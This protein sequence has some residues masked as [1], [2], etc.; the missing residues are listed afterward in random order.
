MATEP[1]KELHPLD[2]SPPSYEWAGTTIGAEMV[3]A[4]GQCGAL[5]R[6]NAMP[7]HT[8]FHQHTTAWL[9]HLLNEK[10]TP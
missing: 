1:L 8:E 3:Y 4:C 5:I 6:A 9:Q 10:A 2:P 7:T